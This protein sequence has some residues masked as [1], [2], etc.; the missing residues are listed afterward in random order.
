M[1]HNAS[2]N[3]FSKIKATD[4]SATSTANILKDIGMIKDFSE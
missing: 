1:K 4:S 2:Y 3:S